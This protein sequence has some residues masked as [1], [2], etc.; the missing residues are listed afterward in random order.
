[1]LVAAN[2]G[3]HSAEG[4]IPE[5]TITL[6]SDI[7]NQPVVAVQPR[8]RGHAR[9]A[10]KQGPRGTVIRDLYQA[11]SAKLVFP[12]SADDGLQ[13]VLVNTAGGITGGDQFDLM[14]EA[15]E[16]TKLVVT[17]QAA[18]RAYGAQQAETGHLATSLKIGAGA[19]LEWLPQETI[20]YEH[21]RFTR[22]LRADLA[23][24]AQLLFVEPLVF[25]RTAMGE[26]LHNIAF[27]DRV[28]IFRNGTPLFCDAMNIDGDAVA[29]L[30]KAATGKGAL[31]MASVVYVAPDAAALLG[32][33]R[34]LLPPTAGASLIGDDLLHIRT[35]AA[36]SFVL[37]RSLMAV[38]DRLSAAALPRTWMI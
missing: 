11:G 21:S 10:T 8:A 4:R 25:G 15:S 6:L 2:V 23:P 9:L 30:S 12:R 29:H 14:F 22:R 17:T 1:M 32:P 36:D 37:R 7:T 26:E 31:A 35:L 38:L 24:D 34:E 13:A 19:R 18:E 20:L 28:E 27:S 33:I 16:A 3:P 5:A